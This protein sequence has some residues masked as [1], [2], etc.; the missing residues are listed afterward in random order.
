MIY[1]KTFAKLDEDDLDHLA[2]VIAS[3]AEAPLL[4]FL[5]GELGAG[6]TRFTKGF[7][8]FFGFPRD[9]VTSPTFNIVKTY[10]TNKVNINHMDAYRL[11][12]TNTSKAWLNEYLIN[13]ITLIE[14]SE[15]V[16]TLLPPFDWR[17]Q[18]KEDDDPT[19]RNITFSCHDKNLL[20]ALGD[21]K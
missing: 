8:A 10:Q 1:E 11:D 15:N 21:G 19:L 2:L 3:K 4:I 6:K 20:Q 17:L 18:I 16:A 5:E 13:S 12:D 14:W 9:E 7:L